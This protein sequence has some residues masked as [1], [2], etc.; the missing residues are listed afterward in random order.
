MLQLANSAVAALCSLTEQLS[1]QCFANSLW[2][3]AR[4][5]LRGP[6]VEA[7]LG[8]S[9]EELGTS[10]HLGIFT[11]QGLANTLWALAEL[12]ASGVALARGDFAVSQ[13]CLAIVAD[14]G[15]RLPEFQPQELSML[16]WSCAKVF[17]KR[18]PTARVSRGR[19]G[20]GGIGCGCPEQVLTFLAELV[21]EASRRL[22]EFTPQGLSNISWTLGTLDLLGPQEYCAPCRSFLLEAM[23]S[24][25]R[26]KAMRG[27]A[28]QA[29]ANLL[30]AAVRLE[31]PPNQK[32]EMSEAVA[33]FALAVVE[34]SRHRFVEFSWRD[35]SGVSV[36]LAHSS[37]CVPEVL[38][39]IEHV[40]STAVVHC[41]ELTPMMMLNIAQSACRLGLPPHKMQGLV[42]SIALAVASHRVRLNEVDARQWQEVLRWCVP[43][44]PGC[45]PSFLGPVPVLQVWGGMP[46]G[47]TAWQ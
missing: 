26:P 24:A 31:S 27:F 17:G 43:S 47:G 8:L 14:A 9:L 40:V 30:W 5:Q 11:S 15:G 34:E 20:R 19:G 39:F 12:H 41:T 38:A 16:A 18:L 45:V 3:A 10:R 28:P 33:D 7:F 42:N 4:L 6:P 32:E 13:I 46:W 23:V 1:A 22:A 35:L 36:A 44:F 21:Q 2:A 29:M 37:L 25:S